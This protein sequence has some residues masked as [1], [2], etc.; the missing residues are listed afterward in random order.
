MDLPARAARAE[1]DVTARFAVGIAVIYN[2]PQARD[3]K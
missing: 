2:Q 3:G 1:E